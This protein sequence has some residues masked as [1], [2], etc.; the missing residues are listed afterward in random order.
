MANIKEDLQRHIRLIA[1][2]LLEND[3]TY[4][5]YTKAKAKAATKNVVAP[6]FVHRMIDGFSKEIKEAMKKMSKK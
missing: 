2:N 6:K 1:G 5:S 4:S 3:L